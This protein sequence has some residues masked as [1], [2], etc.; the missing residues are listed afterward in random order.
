VPKAP[1]EAVR[2]FQA[3]ADPV[4]LRIVRLLLVRPLCVCELT[5][6]LKAE[7]SR[8]SHHL[9]ILRDTGLVKGARQGRWMI[10]R[11]AD[12]GPGVL[13]AALKPALCGDREAFRAHRRDLAELDIAIQDD[14]RGRR[15]GPPPA[16]PRRKGG[17]A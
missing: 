11:I 12:F 4:R 7:Q 8:I 2:F 16:R 3:L 5:F 13:A 9:M 15:C 1:S 14:I 17:S 6:V 10:Y